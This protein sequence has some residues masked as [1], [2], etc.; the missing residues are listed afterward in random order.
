[1]SLK[2]LALHLRKI[3]EDVSIESNLKE[4]L[5]ARVNELFRIDI[6]PAA[7][8][9]LK[10]R[11][12]DVARSGVLL[13]QKKK[14]LDN[15]PFPAGLYGINIF[16]DFSSIILIDINIRVE[17]RQDGSAKIGLLDYETRFR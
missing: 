8:Q 7:A 15:V 12:L 1:M 9:A 14:I 5:Q 10:E 4:F 3:A 11:D 13:I 16:A 6:L 17:V 2:Y